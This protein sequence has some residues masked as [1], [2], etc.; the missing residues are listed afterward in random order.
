VLHCLYNDSDHFGNRKLHHLQIECWQLDQLVPQYS[1]RTRFFTATYQSLIALLGLFAFT[2]CATDNQNLCV[3]KFTLRSIKI[4]DSSQGMVRGEQQKRLYGAVSIEDHKQRI[5]QYYVVSWDLRNQKK[6]TDW[7]GQAQ[8]V[9]RFKQAS[10]G[11]KVHTLSKLY[12]TEIKK[13]KWEINNIG[14]EFSEN[15]RILAWRAD[16]IYG[17]QAIASRESYLWS[18]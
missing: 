5:G 2:S 6:I 16:L 14:D 3:D 13:G 17:G 1:M 18:P 9:F 15:G 12:P 4:E 10:T 8:L 7:N 11:S